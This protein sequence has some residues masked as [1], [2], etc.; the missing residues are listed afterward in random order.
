MQRLTKFEY[1]VIMY[2]KK[3][4]CMTDGYEIFSSPKSILLQNFNF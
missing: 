1:N 4:S 2:L 3:K